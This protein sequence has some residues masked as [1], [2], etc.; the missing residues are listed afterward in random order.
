MPRGDSCSPTEERKSSV[1]GSRSR[2]MTAVVFATDPPPVRSS[3][4][5][6][7]AT[8]SSCGTSTARVA[9]SMRATNITRKRL[10]PM[11]LF[12][13]FSPAFGLA[14]E[15]KTRV[16]PPTFFPLLFQGASRNKSSSIRGCN[17][18]VRRRS[19]V[20]RYG[21]GPIGA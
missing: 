2:M 9:Y 18:S 10:L 1:S 14:A 15:D 6:A 5:L 3:F 19:E 13:L 11:N 21:Y 20:L 12:F 4:V 8:A 17:V 16:R 7:C